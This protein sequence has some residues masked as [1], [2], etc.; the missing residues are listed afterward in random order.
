MPMFTD[1]V[2]GIV[3]RIPEGQVLTYGCLA[4]LAGSPM[5]AMSAGNALG[6]PDEVKGW[7]RVVKSDGRITDAFKAVVAKRQYDLLLE[8]GVGFLEPCRV[9]LARHL[10]EAGGCVKRGCRSRAHR[11]LG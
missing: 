3:R 2:Q 1:S 11:G 9:D 10:W 6:E 4:A 8:D 5:A 7:H